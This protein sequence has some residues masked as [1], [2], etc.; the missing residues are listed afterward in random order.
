M[1]PEVCPIRVDGTYCGEVA[2]FRVVAMCVHEHQLG[3]PCCVT[4]VQDARRLFL[5]GQQQCAAC[6]TGERPHVCPVSVEIVPLA[7]G[8]EEYT[9]AVCH[10]T[11]TKECSD[12]EAAAEMEATWQ[13]LP[14]DDDPGIVCDDCFRQVMAW[15]Q[16][17]AP[18]TLC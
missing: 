11:F 18:E 10:G 4:C 15:A 3:G 1:S 7:S 13:P 2:A 5:A 6:R 14:G 17:E 12:E 8:G 16:S 9:C